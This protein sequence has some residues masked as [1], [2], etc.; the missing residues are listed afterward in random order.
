MEAQRRAALVAAL[1]SMR[2][3]RDRLAARVK[4][5]E[6]ALRGL[7]KVAMCDDVDLQARID[8]RAALAAKEE[9]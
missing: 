7:L 1:E 5:L 9:T 6:E 8:A 2:R 3:E 4:E